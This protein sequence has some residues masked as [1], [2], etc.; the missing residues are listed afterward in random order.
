MKRSGWLD[1]IV[2]ETTGLANPAPIAQTFF[3]DDEVRQR[4]RIDAIVTVVDAHHFL[5]SLDS[6]DPV[7]EKLAFADVILL[8][9]IDIVSAEQLATVKRRIR[10]INAFAPIHHTV[11][12]RSSCRPGWIAGHSTSSAS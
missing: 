4:A 12:A 5:G 9:E 8:N 10:A 11:H 6:S 2:A 7:E 1:G 3:V